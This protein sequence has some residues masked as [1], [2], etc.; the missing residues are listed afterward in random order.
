MSC[1]WRR[2]NAIAAALHFDGGIGYIRAM[3]AVLPKKFFERPV[4]EVAKGLIGAALVRRF[5]DGTTI[6][7]MLTEVEAY[8][9]PED[10][11]S[12]AA[13]GRTPRTEVMFGPAGVFYVYLIYGMHWM[14]NV[15]TGV[16]G[17]PAAVLI[18]GTQDISGPGR[19]T[20]R[21]EIDKSL[22][23]KP[24]KKSSGLWFEDRSIVIPN[25]RIKA[26]PRIGVDYSGA[27]AQV[28]YRF[29]LRE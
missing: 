27:W 18:R 15:V 25:K 11:A 4:L 14:L 3:P 1:R 16:P 2:K 23:G 5:A 29:I 9:G 8:D 12:H 17:H 24:A 22:N 6:S 21:L 7:S 10:L 26:T 19:I 13:K 20:A 28:P